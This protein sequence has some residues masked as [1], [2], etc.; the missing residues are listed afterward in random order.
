MAEL[1][2]VRVD[3][4]LWSVRIF[5]T[6]TQATKAC[7]E[8]KVKC[9]GESLKASKQI[10]VGQV[11]TVRVRYQLHTYKVVKLIEKRVGAAIAETCFEDLTPEEEMQPVHRSAFI[12]V[13]QRERGTGRPT[14]KERRQIDRFKDNL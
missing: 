7:D 4:W 1:K 9:E 11:L 5:K 8:G 13:G 3:K 12:H 14:K 10:E 2:K 6:R